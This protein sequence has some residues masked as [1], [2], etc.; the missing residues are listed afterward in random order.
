MI[1]LL[2]C[3]TCEP[4]KLLCANVVAPRP[5]GEIVIG[6]HRVDYTPQEEPVLYFRPARDDWLTSP[7]R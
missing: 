7:V 6:R 4:S 1:I 3:H 2:L 5:A